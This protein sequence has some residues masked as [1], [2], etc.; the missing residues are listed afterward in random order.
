MSHFE[1]RDIFCGWSIP[2]QSLFCKDIFR[3]VR[4]Q[5]RFVVR[6]RRVNYFEERAFLLWAADQCSLKT[7]VLFQCGGSAERQTHRA[8]GDWW[9]KNGSHRAALFFRVVKLLP[10]FT[11]FLASHFFQFALMWK[12]TAE[13]FVSRGEQCKV[14]L[15]MFPLLYLLSSVAFR[16]VERWNL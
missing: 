10:H 4:H 13:H 14:V 11:S 2:N 6:L 5:I 15:I 1:L 16:N 8:F 12:W 7:T 9:K 3:N